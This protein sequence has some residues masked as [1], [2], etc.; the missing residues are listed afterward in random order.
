MSK[1]IRV[2]FG[3]VLLLA[4]GA[5]L[6]AQDSTLDWSESMRP[7]QILEV[8]TVI[9]DVRVVLA[10]GNE[11][12]IVATKR[13]R[14][15]DFDE[16][17]VRVVEE[18]DGFTLCVVYDVGRAGR[19]GCG[20]GGGD[21]GSRGRRRSIDVEVDFEVEL[22]AGVEFIGASVTGDVD[23]VDVRSDV[24]ASSVSG[25]I[26]VTTTELGYGS[27]VSGDIEIEMGS[28]DW[29]RL[30]FHTVSGDITL[31]LPD[32]LD[33]NVRFES[34]SGDFDSDFDLDVTRRRDRFIG[35]SIRATIGE[36]GR[37]LSFKTVSGDV[38]LRRNRRAAPA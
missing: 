36:G 31:S 13:G 22:P 11:A 23:V 6:R 3:T 18:R 34:L 32:G 12:R 1:T 19:D 2:V 24:S 37:D 8:K 15:S 7:G 17:E 9:G 26:F 5:P 38:R 25:N 16:V 35:S 10:S 28:V 4:A 21:H 30:D 20:H 29:D 33:A 27:T 14:R